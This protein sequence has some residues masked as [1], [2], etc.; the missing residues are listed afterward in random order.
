MLWMMFEKRRLSATAVGLISD[1]ANSLWVSVS[2]LWETAIKIS[3]GKLTIPGS[4]IKLVFDN[5]DSYRIELLPIRPDHLR[6]L[7]TLP[8]LHRDPFDRI[9]IVQSMSEGFPLI[10]VDRHIRRY[11]LETRW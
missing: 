1:P 4:D 11:E 5:L 8:M 2:S 7:Q 3:I 6:L 10:T 9:L